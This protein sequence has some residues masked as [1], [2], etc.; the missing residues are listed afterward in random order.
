MR[1][2]MWFEWLWRRWQELPGCLSERT[3]GVVAHRGCGR[4]RLTDLA[5]Q[6]S[7]NLVAALILY[8]ISRNR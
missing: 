3:R 2:R 6:V 1:I 7:A 4:R 8:L 5:V